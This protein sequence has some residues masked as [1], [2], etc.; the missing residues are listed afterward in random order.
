MTR[1]RWAPIA[2]GV[3]VLL[4]FLIL[5]GAVFSISWVREHLHVAP[6]SADEASGAF[7]AVH[8][9]FPDKAPMVEMRDGL[10]VARPAT[11]TTERPPAPLSRVNLVAWDPREARLTRFDMPFWVLRLKS[12]PIR[13][14]SYATGLDEA[15]LSLRAEDIERNGPGVVLDL[16]LPRGVRVLLWAE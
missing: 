7:E 11:A 6:S 12:T 1:R 8:A 2:A 9:R 14:G 16:M 13:F 4:V 10:L 3:A 5:G 15:G